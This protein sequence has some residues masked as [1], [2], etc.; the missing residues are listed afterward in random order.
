MKLD[1]LRVSDAARILNC[2]EETVR[3]LS[4]AEVLTAHRTPGGFRFFERSDVE[5]LLRSRERKR[6]RARYGFE[7]RRRLKNRGQK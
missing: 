2:S 5:A 1:L 6:K 4:D 7:H 3:N